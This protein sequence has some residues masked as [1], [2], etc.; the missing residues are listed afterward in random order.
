MI[1]STR[2]RVVLQFTAKYALRHRLLL[3]IL[4]KLFVFFVF[5]RHYYPT[6]TA[7][8]PGV[9]YGGGLSSVEHGSV[10]RGEAPFDL[11]NSIL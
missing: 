1:R 6:P 8:V 5:A 7:V 11:H 10:G 3:L 2:T 9:A 4:P